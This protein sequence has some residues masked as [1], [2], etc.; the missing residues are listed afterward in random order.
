MK[1]GFTLIEIIVSL[2][3]FTVV[4]VV[5]VGAFLKII[6]A[7]KKAQ[8]LQTAMNNI[9]FALESMVREIRVGSNYYCY[10]DV[11]GTINFPITSV[12]N[13]SCATASAYNA[14]AFKSADKGVYSSGHPGETCNLV[15]AYRYVSSTG[16]VEKA[17]QKY[18]DDVVG[19][20]TTQQTGYAPFFELTA[21]DL[22][23]DKFTIKVDSLSPASPNAIQPKLFILISGHSGSGKS[24]SYFNVQTSA[25]Q[26]IMN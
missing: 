9:N 20:G 3:I 11:S 10:Q 12:T 23:I 26:R 5:A 21:S 7:N 15:H 2:A 8:T 25:S 14:V 16:Y 6:D 1:K 22:K 13:T 24:A 17:E 19:L 4:A 18:C